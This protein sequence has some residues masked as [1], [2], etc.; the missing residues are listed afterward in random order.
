MP[1]NSTS[2]SIELPGDLFV[3]SFDGVLLPGDGFE[4]PVIVPDKGEPLPEVVEVLFEA[5]YLL[6][7]VGNLVRRVHCS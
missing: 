2:S 5:L 4:V 6:F 7:L 3:D 1:S